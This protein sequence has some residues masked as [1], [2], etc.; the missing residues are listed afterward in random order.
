MAFDLKRFRASSLEAFEAESGIC[1]PK[2]ASSLATLIETVEDHRINLLVTLG[3][4]YGLHGLS[5]EHSYSVWWLLDS[6][7]YSDQDRAYL[8][9]L[10]ADQMKA[11]CDE[12]A[13]QLEIRRLTSLPYSE[14]LQTPH[15][16]ETRQRTLEADLNR[17]RVCNG[18][19]RLNAHHRTY[20]RRGHEAAEDL[21]TLCA[22]C[23]QIFHQNGKL[24]TT[25]EAS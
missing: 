5:G 23:H 3:M 20:S 25:P 13:R 14:Y 2:L 21:I 11:Y 16:K 10:T 8:L 18:D 1:V 4:V 12:D 9:G 7:G 6:C 22:S 17:C 15:W 19:E 24:A